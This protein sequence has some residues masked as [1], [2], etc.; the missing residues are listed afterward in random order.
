MAKQ[1]DVNSEPKHVLGID[2]L[3]A[4][5]VW[6]VIIYHLN[7][8]FLP[9]GFVGVDI[10]FAISGFVITKSLLERQP[11]SLFSFFT[12]FYRRRFVRIAPA[13]FVYL[14]VVT[15]LSSYFIPKASLSGGIFETAKWAVFGASN[16]QLVATN[17]G[18][19]AER[20]DYNPFIQT[21]SLGVEEQFYLLYPLFMAFLVFAI[22]KSRTAFSRI[23]I[24][25]LGLLTIASLAISGKQTGSD[26]LSAFYLL[27]S[28]FWE[29]AAGGL[30][31]ILVTRLGKFSNQSLAA[32]RILFTVATLL[33]VPSLL[34]ADITQFPFWW[35][36]PPVLGALLLIHASNNASIDSAS[37]FAK[38]VTSRPIVY[39][40]KISYSLYLWHW[41]VFVLMRWTIGLTNWWQ[42]LLALVVTVLISAFSYKF[43]ETPV[44]SGKFFRKQPDWRIIIAG[45]LVAAMAV[46]VASFGKTEWI[47]RAHAVNDPKFEDSKQIAKVLATIPASEIG[48][49]HKVIFVG[50]SHSGHYKYMSHWIA[51][52][53]GADVSRII[54][55]GCGYVNLQAVT[56][57]LTV[58]PTDEKITSE[59]LKQTKPGDVIVLSSFSTPR[60]SA[61]DG[62]YNQA[63]ILTQLNS[64]EKQAGRAEALSAATKVVSQLQSHGLLVILA[65]PTPVFITPPDRCNKWFNK[66]NPICSYGFKQ[67][68]G[69]EQELRA[70]V[71]ASYNS[72]AASTGAT[73][74]DPFPYLCNDGKYCYSRKD[75]RYLFVDQ[76][77]LT[78][79]GNILLVGSFIDELKQIWL[80]RI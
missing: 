10:F 37:P 22:A 3:R 27:P 11:K 44:R 14:M 18:Y 19:F 16:L 38:F 69:Y 50:D 6:V 71:M 4:L 66:I 45:V 43:I 57:R 78:A 79:N 31:Y 72:L 40:G 15:T 13:L 59:I 74:W 41:G 12:G 39:F 1:V 75:G 80:N 49:G 29:L 42:Y 68:I 70:P 55:Y 64:P 54:H 33:I 47:R 24:S 25:A 23:I 9:G 67:P 62:P 5:A 20:M 60:I 61:S 52:K 34:I 73:L 7:P 77:H 28:R 35:A 17:D 76:H 51:A 58:C 36:I 32:K 63:D 21:W 26:F 65:A 8:N 48:A 46:G 56:T 30:L 53:T 2:S